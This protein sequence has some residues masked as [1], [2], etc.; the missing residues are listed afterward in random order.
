MTAPAT[1]AAAEPS[2]SDST[3]S[4]APCVLSVRVA[5]D[6]IHAVTR[7]TTRPVNGDRQDDGAGDRRR[8]EQPGHRLDDDEHDEPQQRQRVDERRDHFG[9]RVAVR[10]TAR[11]RP[12]RD[13][14][15]EQ[16]EP[17][18]RGVGQHVAGVRQERERS[19]P[20]SADRLDDREPAG[21]RERPDQRAL[22]R[23]RGGRRPVQ[24]GWSCSPWPTRH[25]PAC[26]RADAHAQS[27]NVARPS[28]PFSSNRRAGGSTRHIRLKRC[29]N[30]RD[31]K[32]PG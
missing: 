18:R 12:C 27:A 31:G 32:M 4:S 28:R 9:A 26:R 10:R 23:R 7:L 8:R 20:P 6:R 22:R 30:A 17:E 5:R 25:G 15:G 29:A 3:C 21:Q 19:R 24:M 13:A 1:I 2:R 11:R 16:R 14:L